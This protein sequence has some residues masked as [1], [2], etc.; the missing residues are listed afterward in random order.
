MEEKK[1]RKSG[2]ARS[3]R[4]RKRRQKRKVTMIFMV[5]ICILVFIL[6]VLEMR[7]KNT[8]KSDTAPDFADTAVR[9][10]DDASQ[11]TEEKILTLTEE[12]K[13]TGDLLLVN[14]SYAYDFDANADTINLVNIRDTQSFYY[15]VQKTDYEVAGRIMP[16]LDDLVSACDSAVGSRLTGIASAY[17]SLEYQQDV[18]NEMAELYGNEYAETYV[19]V[20]GYSEHHTG[21]AVD[22]SIFFEDGSEGTFSESENAAWMNDNSYHYGFVRRYAED[23]VDVTGISNEAWHFRFVGIPHATFMVNNNL[24]LEEYIDYLRSH[25][26]AANPLEISCDSGTYEVYFTAENEITE[27]EGEYTVSGNNVDGYIITVKKS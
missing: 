15:Q 7:N 1:K 17:R 5:I 9:N 6:V 23:K 2:R 11:V 8:G 26:D 16:Y 3:R 27:P 12:Q 20:P 24:C 14:S 19:A 21:L 18:W 4:E 10:N 25:T 22:M 13:H